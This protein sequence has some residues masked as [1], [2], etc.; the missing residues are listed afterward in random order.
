VEKPLAQK[1][2][3]IIEYTRLLRGASKRSPKAKAFFE[4][5]K[6]DLR[7]RKQAETMEKLMF[8]KSIPAF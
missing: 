6:A 4:K 2:P 5:H 7:F 1:M 8:A 3:P